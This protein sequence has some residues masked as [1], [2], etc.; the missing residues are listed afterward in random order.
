MARARETFVALFRGINVGG[1]NLLPMKVLT[2]MF[3]RA[4]GADVRTYIQSG[5]VVFVASPRVAARIPKLVTTDIARSAGLRVPVVLRSAAEMR[6]VVKSN[7]FLPHEAN[8]KALHVLF[9]EHAPDAAARAALDPKR[10]PPDAF[11]VVGRE[12][13]LLCPNGIARTKLTNAYF[14]A[15]LAT[16]STARNWRTVLTLVEMCG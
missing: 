16:T 6:A 8:D 3:E 7:P 4:G 11:A 14:D 15:A 2:E 12:V 13:Y 10:S 9:L 5:N 1:K